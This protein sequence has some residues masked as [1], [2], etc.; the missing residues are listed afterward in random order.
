[1]PI[2]T[3][4][5]DY[6]P[7]SFY[8]GILRGALVAAVKDVTVIDLTH[9]I[10]KYNSVDAAFLLR[11]S[12]ANFPKGT[13]HLIA[14]SAEST[15]K[16]PHR[17][18]KIDDQY[19]IGADTGTFHL[20]FGKEPDAVYDM[21]SMMADFDY[22]S[23]PERAMFVPAAA[24]LARGGIPELLGRPSSLV[25]PKSILKPVYEDH[26]LT[27]HVIH[28]D[29]FGNCVTDI[30][31]ALF[32]EVGTERGFFIVMRSS[33]SDIR[34]IDITYSDVQTGDSVAIFN[35]MGLLEIAVNRGAPASG[36]GG[37]AS[38]LGIKVDD[39]I[40]IEFSK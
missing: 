28:I 7:E 24:H 39:V 18:V 6:G 17:I 32:R 35:H 13:I 25:N 10:R 27:G 2:I 34:K 30:D 15:P 16:C 21:S 22:P 29:G 36:H 11:S 31:K 3:L 4:I 12:V 20:I 5:S 8:A 38:L 33:R 40:R 1:V 23:F 14:V 9:N 26:V 19:F 37:A